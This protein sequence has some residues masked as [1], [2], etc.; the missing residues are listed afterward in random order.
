MLLFHVF[1][2]LTVQPVQGFISPWFGGGT[3]VLGDAGQAHVTPQ[4]AQQP[5]GSAAPWLTSPAHLLLS[6]AHT[7]K[8]LVFL[9][10]PLAMLLIPKRSMGEVIPC[11]WSPEWSC[12]CCVPAVQWFLGSHWLFP[13][14]EET[15]LSYFSKPLYEFKYSLLTKC[16][17]SQQN[18]NQITCGDNI[19]S[20]CNQLLTHIV[21]PFP[22]YYL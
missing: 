4:Q 22:C 16:N 8:C 1:R 10:L 14:R 18:R 15:H 17:F 13:L 6:D 21:C 3:H 5:L 11:C 19:S 20:Y 12:Q 7:G 2:Q 9:S